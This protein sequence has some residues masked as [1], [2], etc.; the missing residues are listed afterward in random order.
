MRD[1]VR[2]P[3]T[4]D[5]D[6]GG[7]HINSGI[8]NNAFYRVAVALGGNSWDKAG[9]IWYRTLTSPHLKHNASFKNF[10]DVTA[11]VALA[12]YGQEVKD[13]VVKAWT[14]VGVH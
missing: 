13:I 9:K 4:E 8:P 7:V 1:Y 6:S 5:G 14:D 3:N 2:L 12:D 10:A 11:E